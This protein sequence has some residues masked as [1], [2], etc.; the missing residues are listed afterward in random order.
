MNITIFEQQLARAINTSQ[1]DKILS[2]Y[3]ADL[4]ITNFSFTYYTY[5]TNSKSKIKYDFSSES[6]KRWHA[7]YLAENYDEVDR[8]L[9][10]EYRGVLPVFWHIDTQ[11]KNAKGRREKKMRLDSKKFGA[12]QGLSIPIHGPNDDFANLMVE[13]V[14]RQHCLENW[15]ELKYTLL[16]AAYCYYNYLQKCLLKQNPNTEK[17]QFSTREMQ[18]INLVAKNYPVREIAK[19]LSIT[20]RTV[21]FHIQ[22]V[23]KRLGVNNKYQ[24]VAI[25]LAQK[26]LSK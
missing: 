1:L 16:S 26:S 14:V 5:H 15:Q 9:D 6:L 11:I 19:I 10:T 21:N 17:I 18:V 24:S 8:V 4:G 3:L 12:V 22:N 2:N 20:E 13:Q 25:L 23:N 7:H